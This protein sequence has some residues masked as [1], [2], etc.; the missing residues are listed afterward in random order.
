MSDQG[1]TRV[2]RIHAA[3]GHERLRLE[4]LPMPEPGAGEARVETRA[5]GV[6]YADCVVRMGL[7]ASAKEYVGWPI[8]PGFEFAGTV[9]ATGANVGLERG[10]RVFG[11]TR[12]GAYASHVVVPGHQLFALP[13]RWSFA[14]AASFPTVFLT[15]WYALRELCKL[16]AGMR[17]LVHSAAGGVGCA[18][19]QLAAACGCEVTAVVGAA[20]KERT[21]RASGATHVIDRSRRRLGKALGEIAP[22]GFDV[23]LDPNGS[24]TLALSYRHLAPAGRLIVYGFHTLMARGKDRPSYVKLLWGYL[25]TPRFNPFH[26]NQHNKSVLAFNLSY[27]FERSALLAEAMSEL[28]GW[29]QEGKLRPLPLQE[30]PLEHAARAHAALESAQ[31]VGKLVLIP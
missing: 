17:V 25:R 14:E 6:N 13:E 11:V 10:Q 27:L 31:S 7:Y 22:R 24:A 29:V 2:I 4:Q 15:A 16:R 23:V 19:T 1:R 12:F 28:L 5:I 18:A 21:A 8:T 20:H 9:D 26:M 30:I 3:G